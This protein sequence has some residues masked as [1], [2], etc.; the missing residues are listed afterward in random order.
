M[1]FQIG[2]HRIG[3]I[4][5][6]TKGN[7]IAVLFV[8]SQKRG[9]WI[10]PK[11]IPKPNESHLSACQ[12]ESFEEAGVRGKVLGDFP[13]TGLITKYAEHRKQQFPVTYYPMLVND[14][15]NE[16][17]EQDRRER[18]WVLLQDASHAAYRDDLLA[19]IQDFESLAPWIR[20]LAENYKDKLQEEPMQEL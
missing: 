1:S 12:R 19:I 8:T 3:S 20:E 13:L 7:S 2:A 9:R 5:F 15:F 10:L 11:G 14:Q 4:P 18:H 17:P 6:A 16:W